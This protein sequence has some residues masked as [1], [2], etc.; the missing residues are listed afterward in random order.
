MNVVITGASSGIGYQTAYRFAVEHGAKVV[1]IARRGN[2]LS[3][4]RESVLREDCSGEIIPIELDLERIEKAD[5]YNKVY[6]KVDSV[7]ILINNA[8]KLFSKPFLEISTDDLKSM[9]GV[10]VFSIYMVIQALFPLMEKGKWKHIV[11]ITSIGGLGGTQKFS[12]LSGYSSSKGAVTILTECLAEE[13]R[14]MGFKVN[15]LAFGAVQTE[16]LSKAFPGYVAPV[17]DVEIS[18]FLMDFSM[19]GHQFFNGKVLPVSSTNP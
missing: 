19:K 2:R 5:L 14:E 18:K 11:N 10:N 4:L 3:E 9:Y 6:N 12:G 7:D 17:T 13:M 1:A 8:A 15:G 16:M